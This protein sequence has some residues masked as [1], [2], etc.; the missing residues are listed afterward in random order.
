[1]FH[2]HKNAEMAAAEPFPIQAGKQ[3]GKILVDIQYLSPLQAD[4]RFMAGS[5]N[6]LM[7]HIPHFLSNPLYFSAFSQLIVKNKIIQESDQP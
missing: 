6:S 3:I 2:V 5:R 1:M 4:S 7:I